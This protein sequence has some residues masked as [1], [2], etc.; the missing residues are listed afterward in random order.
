MIGHSVTKLYGE[1]FNNYTE[2]KEIR[3]L[4]HAGFR[5][6]FSTS[7]HILTLRWLLKQTKMQKKWLHGWSEDFHQAFDLVPRECFL[8]RLCFVHSKFQ[9]G[10]MYALYKQVLGWVGWMSKET[11]GS[12]HK[13]HQCDARMLT[14]PSLFGQYINKVADYIKH[15][16][17]KESAY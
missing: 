4:G 3:V 5:R 15:G 9:G 17:G 14:L 12:N 6:A 2:I 13:Y 1:E 7:D 11:I 10:Y 16:G 8:Q